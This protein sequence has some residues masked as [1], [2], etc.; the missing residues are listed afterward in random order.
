MRLLLLS[1][2]GGAG[3]S[4]IAR[5]TALQAVADGASVQLI[6]LS[7][8]KEAS[9][10][11]AAASQWLGALAADVLVLRDA[12]Q[13]LP[14]ELAMLPGIDDFLALAAIAESATLD[15]ADLVIVDAGPLDSLARLLMTADTLDLLAGS[16]MT[17][18]LAIAREN[19][20]TPL[21]DL[22]DELQRIRACLE[23][24]DTCIRLVCLPEERSIRA[25]DGAL[26]TASLYG[27]HVDL[28]YVNQ[29]PRSKDS[30]PKRWALARRRM[31][32]RI[33]EH[34]A[35]LP[36]RQLPMRDG[37]GAPVVERIRVVAKGE[38]A[39][40]AHASRAVESIDSL[41]SGFAWSLPVHVPATGELRLGRADDRVIIEI[42]GVTRVRTLPSV[43][44]RC[45]ITRAVA[46][47]SGLRIELAPDP[48]VWRSN[49]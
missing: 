5:A 47:P 32:E 4:T 48:S 21:N 39:W 29:V 1:G 23:S 38:I 34:L 24:I 25:I 37:Q 7:D 10:A 2:T 49:G 11:R 45:E 44:R 16:L 30:W 17:P 12:E 22:R 35:D 40:A 13:V 46:S 9:A 14:E 3:T 28:V 36:V 26:V 18:A 33:A 41:G 31:A 43:L 8:Y 27:T 19:L 20:D 42:D 15:D 6:D